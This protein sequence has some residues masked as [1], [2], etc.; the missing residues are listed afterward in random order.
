MVHHQWW[1]CL[2]FWICWK[3]PSI[4]LIFSN[5]DSP[6]LKRHF[7]FP[8]SISNYFTF[9]FLPIPFSLFIYIYIY[10]INFTY[11]SMFC[12]N[13]LIWWQDSIWSLDTWNSFFEWV[14]SSLSIW[15]KFSIIIFFPFL[16]NYILIPYLFLFCLNNLK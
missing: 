12:F 7:C 1:I 8:P 13:G 11:F 6:L 9:I 15:V 14:F 4:L 16:K 5:E 3:P 10:M 2:F